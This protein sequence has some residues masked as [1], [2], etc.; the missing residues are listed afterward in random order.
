MKSRLQSL[1]I[2][3]ITDPAQAAQMLLASRF[4]RHVLWNALAL[5]VV[6]NALIYSA[7]EMLFP[8]PTDIVIPRLPAL[9]Y[10][11]VMLGL[12]IIFVHVLKI[13]GKWLGGQGGLHDILVLVVWLQLL[14]VLVQVVMT[15]LFVFTPVFAG[16]LNLAI[17][18]FSI[19]ILANFINEAHQLKS[20]WRA[21]GVLLMASAII[22][23]ALSFLLGLAGPSLLGS[24][25]NV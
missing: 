9:A 13:A 12:Q 7:Q 6:L 2:L 24:S 14:Q 21:F 22:A 17:M 19:Y 1:V 20:V 15:V 23:L 25:A 18:L 16:L 10:F 5:A 4:S 8:L 11:F 3:T